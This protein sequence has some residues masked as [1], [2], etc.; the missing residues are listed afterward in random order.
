MC[1]KYD[2]IVIGAGLS[3]L[4]AA[5]L[6]AKRGLKVAA[7]DRNDMPGGSCGI[8]RRG[9]ATFDYGSSMLYGWGDAG[10]NPHRFVM[11][12][13][14]EP[15]D[16]IK[17]DLLYCV[18]YEGRRIRFWADL[19][20]FAAEL[21]E[22][23]PTEKEHILRFYRDLGVIYRHVMVETPTYASPDETDPKQGLKSLLKHPISYFRFLSYLNMSAETL[24]KRYF[25][26]PAIFRFFDKLTSTYCYTTVKETPAILAA[27]MFVDNHIGG[28]YYPAGSTLFLPGKLEKAIEENGGTMI[29]RK[30]V[31]K[32]VFRDGRPAGVALDDGSMLEADDIVHSGSVWNLYG[33]LVRDHADPKRIAWAENLESTYPSVMLYT[34]VDATAIPAGT[35]P[36]EMLVGNPERI[37]ESEVTV[38][39]TSIDDRTV[40][41]A[42]AH[43]VM[44]IGPSFERWDRSDRKAYQ[45]M[46]AK[47]KAR[48]LGVLERRFPGISEHVRYADVGTP[49]TIERYVMKKGGAVAGPK[50]KLGQHMFR[51]LHIKSEW[52]TLFLC[53]EST[54]MG[55]GTPA[56]TTSGLSAANAILRKRGLKTFVH[57]PGRENV[58][59]IVDKP[60][61]PGHLYQDEAPADR[62]VM[63]EAYRCLFCEHPSCA[64]H[65]VFDVR[66]MNRR[67]A[68]GNVVGACRIAAALP[69][70]PMDRATFLN[71]CEGGCV[72]NKQG[73]RPVAIRAIA[74]FL[75]NLK[76][77][78]ERAHDL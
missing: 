47:E 63:R 75:L 68:V 59:R 71:A 53:G 49:A 58:V 67:V 64:D 11:N 7:I 24:L 8:F 20:R 78:G 61:L 65:A 54:I 36:V 55:T 66:G 35:L 16:I 25:R 70:D 41:P 69:D 22:V 40:C 38:Y 21:G 5:A 17:H 73:D 76:T 23:F 26:D 74:G 57:D 6:L 33:K 13:L 18:V 2:V 48:L 46:K 12:C 30:E 3:G 9:E 72:R 31:V 62:A 45:A 42:D 1:M 50:Q 51:R 19:D 10:F 37:D 15:I 44:A 56:V 34:L 77:E 4:T 28:S 39:I 29:L 52:P 27:V 60:F 43:I 14:E 32:I